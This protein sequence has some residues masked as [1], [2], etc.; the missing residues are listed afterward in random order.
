MFCNT[1]GI[2]KYLQFNVYIKVLKFIDKEY[3]KEIT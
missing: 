3:W 2:S 1:Q